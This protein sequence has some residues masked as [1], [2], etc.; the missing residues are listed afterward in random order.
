MWIVCKIFGYNPFIL[1]VLYWIVNCCKWCK[2]CWNRS[3]IKIFKIFSKY[4]RLLSVSFPKPA[5]RTGNLLDQK[6]IKFYKLLTLWKY[7]INGSPSKNPDIKTPLVAKNEKKNNS[8]RNTHHW[9]RF[10][11]RV[12]RRTP[13]IFLIFWLL[14]ILSTSARVIQKFEFSC[15][16][17]WKWF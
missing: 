8:Q 16:T 14:E 11:F 12:H 7:Y 3:E 10:D 15:K 6:R 13:I 9:R 17:S 5:M 1:Q 2:L 4:S